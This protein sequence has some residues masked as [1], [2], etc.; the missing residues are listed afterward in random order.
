[1]HPYPVTIVLALALLAGA[2]AHGGGRAGKPNPDLAL[3][4]TWQAR[5]AAERGDDP[6]AAAL[7]AKAYSLGP[8]DPRSAR[9]N[10]L[11]Y[12]RGLLVP[13][14]VALQGSPVTDIAFSPLGKRVLTG[15]E[16]GV[17]IWDV[18]S[19]RK[20]SEDP[21]RPAGFALALMAG[22][23][24]GVI[25][26]LYGPKGRRY[27]FIH[28]T[29][30]ISLMDAG[31]GNRIATL[32]GSRAAFSPDGSFIA[33]MGSDGKARIHEA[34]LGTP[35][36]IEVDHLGGSGFYTMTPGLAF[37][38]DGGRLATCGE[39]RIQVW[40]VRTGRPLGDAISYVD[41]LDLII[42]GVEAVR[43][44]PDGKRLLSVTHRRAQIYEAETGKP[45]GEPMRHDGLITDAAIGPNGRVA[46]A[47]DD[48]N[49]KL[50]GR[51]GE[52]VA[53]TH[54]TTFRHN[55]EVSF[56]A[57]SPDG[58]LLMSGSRD[59]TARLWGMK[60]WQP[61]GAPM[62]HP[63]PVTAGAFS[64][65]GT[66]VLTGSRDQTLRLWLV[67]GDAKESRGFQPGKAS[68]RSFSPDLS[69]VLGINYD[70]TYRLWDMKTGKPTSGEFK[71]GGRMRGS[72]FSPSGT[73]F[74]TWA[75]D[76]KEVRFWSAKDGKPFLVKLRHSDTVWDGEFSPDGK[77]VA[78]GGSDSFARL[79]DWATG[80][81]VGK[82]MRHPTTVY[83]LFFSPDGARLL[84]GCHDDTARVWNVPS[85]EP[86]G[87]PIKLGK[88]Y[89]IQGWSSDGKLFAA[90]D[91]RAY[92]VRVW[93]AAQGRRAAPPPAKG[94]APPA[95]KPML[96]Q[97]RVAEV[98]F[99]PAAPLMVTASYDGTA[100][101]WDPRTGEPV[102][103]IMRHPDHVWAVRFSPDGKLLATG[104]RDG[105][106]RIWSTADGTLVGKPIFHGR[107]IVSTLDFSKDGRTLYTAGGFSVRRWALSWL[108]D[109]SKPERVT[110]L[111]ERASQRRI[112]S[113]GFVE[114]IPFDEWAPRL[115]PQTAA[116]PAKQATGP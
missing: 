64:P 102:G 96:H 2:C 114:T 17:R 88:D 70:H 76:D 43:F 83:A 31:T 101:L 99:S 80:K 56:V 109:E 30:R 78:T 15:G 50:W 25:G 53:W 105:F 24:K 47:G 57:F 20:I 90:V 33:V 106:A 45:I 81:V 66:R 68:D 52:D 49:V 69:R 9:A 91:N 39:K 97:D 18:P 3:A 10:A 4:Y 74:L 21:G 104:S 46:T 77:L 103:M 112:D 110:S 51:H 58:S 16:G 61:H 48:R 5:L 92:E 37:S 95:P 41:K 89:K 14:R 22:A 94:E 54:L 55:D 65:G 60:T 28:A 34:K 67:P 27:L 93:D 8:A 1:M 62:Y 72:A 82:P 75:W 86:A 73:R 116:A 108:H 29:A 19:M 87:G 11:A 23:G 84:T 100:R 40:D 85:G 98:A 6:S 35:T 26:T 59:G 79:W 36:G 115:E 32:K 13:E 63:A 12:T 111:A 71:H 42:G 107:G 7:F 113:R 44:S 38:P